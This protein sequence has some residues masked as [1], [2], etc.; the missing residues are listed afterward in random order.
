MIKVGL[1]GLG[2]GFTIYSIT[3]VSLNSRIMQSRVKVRVKVRG[4]FLVLKSF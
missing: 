1:M 2:F 4:D 3:I